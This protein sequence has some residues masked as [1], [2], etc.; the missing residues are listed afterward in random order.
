M[1]E[2][3]QLKRMG[4]KFA[5]AEVLRVLGYMVSKKRVR[6]TM[7]EEM[8][9]EAN[10]PDTSWSGVRDSVGKTSKYDERKRLHNW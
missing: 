4:E 1:V 3:I 7:L 10:Q 9:S 2:L 8:E 6:T 5:Q